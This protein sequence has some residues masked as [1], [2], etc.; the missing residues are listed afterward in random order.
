M[1]RNGSRNCSTVGISE[2]K[3]HEKL[4]ENWNADDKTMNEFHSWLLEQKIDFT[5]AEF[6]QDYKWIEQRLQS[7]LYKTG[8]NIEASDRYEIRIDPEVEAAVNALPKATALLANAKKIVAE[9]VKK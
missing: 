5:E 7:E 2:F 8:F 4:P 6:T 3:H 1:I 9:R